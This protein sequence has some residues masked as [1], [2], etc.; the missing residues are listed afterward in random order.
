MS[1]KKTSL[2]FKLIQTQLYYL[3][4]ALLFDYKKRLPQ[5]YLTG[6]VFLYSQKYYPIKS[7][8]HT[9]KQERG[10]FRKKYEPQI[11]KIKKKKI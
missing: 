9:K 1:I 8:Q 3:N 7:Y 4:L 10:F 5:L 6:G 2:L 11:I